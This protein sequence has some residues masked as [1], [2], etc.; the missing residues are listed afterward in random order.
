MRRLTTHSVLFAVVVLLGLAQVGW[1]TWFQFR[2]TGVWED[3]GHRLAAGDV[4]GAMRALGANEGGD[5]VDQARRRRLMF[6]SEGATLSL[7]VLVG[8]VWFYATLL[9][10]RRM[11]ETQERF[12]AGTT[13][14][15]K[16]PL[17]TLRIGL[18]SLI[19]D[20]LPAE[21]R[22]SY[23]ESMLEQ[24]R[25]LENGVGNLLMAADPHRGAGGLVVVDGDLVQDIHDA[26]AEM[27]TRF[28]AADVRLALE[29]PP[30]APLARDAAAVRLILH[31]LLDNAVKLAPQGSVVR[32]RLSVTATHAT[33][34]VDDEGPGVDDADLPRIFD[35]FYRGRRLAHAGG[36]GLGL[37]IARQLVVRHGGT[38]TVANRD[39]RGTS[40]TITLPRGGPR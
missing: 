20:R 36:T 38:I 15:W 10:E 27:T 39:V 22:R 17:A 30:S 28:K 31:N 9:R 35:R 19:D 6:V 8:V 24:T 37:F 2:E 5:I 33:I 29:L 16:T 32:V 12:L 1:W 25:R 3:V 14:A 7:L 40:F 18:E 26:D 23:L 4:D 34:V 21:R 13:H 11:H